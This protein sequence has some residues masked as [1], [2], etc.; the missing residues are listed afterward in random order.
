MSSYC[1]SARLLVP[2]Y[3]AALLTTV[4]VQPVYWLVCHLCRVLA[5]LNAAAASLSATYI[6]R[7][8]LTAAAGVDAV[9]C[10]TGVL[11]VQPVPDDPTHHS[12]TAQPATGACRL[13][14]S[15]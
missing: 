7:L 2:A 15:C 6:G 9:Y 12:R 3:A 11:G 13:C 1:R 8:V 5:A 14:C 10:C 4:V